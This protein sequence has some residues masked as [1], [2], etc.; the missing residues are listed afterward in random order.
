[1]AGLK[2]FKDCWKLEPIIET[3]DDEPTDDEID[4]IM[5]YL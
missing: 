1:M 5:A 3:E 2:K 4:D